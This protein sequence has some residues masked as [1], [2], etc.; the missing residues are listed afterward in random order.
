MEFGMAVVKLDIEAE[1]LAKWTR[2]NKPEQRHLTFP[3]IFHGKPVDKLLPR[4]AKQIG[5]VWFYHEFEVRFP[6]LVSMVTKQAPT[7]G[8]RGDPH[9]LPLAPN[10][11]RIRARH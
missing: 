10:V 2:E 6:P 8:L 3:N 4:F 9:R 5:G 11:V 7:S 1:R